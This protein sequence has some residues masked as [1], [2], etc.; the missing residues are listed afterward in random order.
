[1]NIFPSLIIHIWVSSVIIP[2]ASFIY[3]VRTFDPYYIQLLLL[4]IFISRLLFYFFNLNKDNVHQ[5]KNILQKSFVSYFNFK[6]INYKKFPSQ[7]KILYAEFPHGIFCFSFFINYAFLHPCKNCIFDLLVEMPVF[8]DFVKMYGATGC[9]KELVKKHMK[10]NENIHLLPGG[11]HE[12]CSIKNFEYNLYVPTGFIALCLQ[13]NYTI[14]PIIN[15]GENETY[16]ILPL[17]RKVY[18]FIYRYVFKFIKIPIFIGI[19]KYFTLM[20]IKRTIWSIYGDP[21]ECKLDKDETTNEAIYR[22]RKTI[23]LDLV[24]MFENN[25]QKYCDENKYDYKKYKIQ[26]LSNN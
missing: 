17:H 1:M 13:Y 18:N 25:I 20:P 7:S 16:Y 8:G 2:I 10:N 14:V 12:I 11:F 23:C 3:T 22:I 6:T 26:I 21:I 19:G 24:K 5:L 9:K 4:I 15:I